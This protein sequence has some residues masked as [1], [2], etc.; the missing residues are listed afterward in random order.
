M[1]YGNEE[2]FDVEAGFLQLLTDQSRQ[3]RKYGFAHKTTV[4][5]HSMEMMDRVYNGI[6]FILREA[7]YEANKMISRRIV[8]GTFSISNGGLSLE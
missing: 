1:F 3:G 7:M 8:D 4:M 2:R 6:V 5:P